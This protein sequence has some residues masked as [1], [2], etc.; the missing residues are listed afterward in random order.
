MCRF[1]K[2][3]QRAGASQCSPAQCNMQAFSDR[4]SD[5]AWNLGGIAATVESF[6]LAAPDAQIQPGYRGEDCYVRPS[7]SRRVLY[8]GFPESLSQAHRSG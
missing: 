3:L 7:R 1:P 5:V 8:H 4:G 6:G 2:A